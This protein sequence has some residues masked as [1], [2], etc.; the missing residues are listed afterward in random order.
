MGFNSAFKGLNINTK[1]INHYVQLVN[2]YSVFENNKLKVFCI[3]GIILITIVIN[4]IDSIFCV[5]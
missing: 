4:N 1:D 3:N 5:Q 2:V